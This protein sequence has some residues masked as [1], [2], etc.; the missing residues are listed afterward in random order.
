MEIA[1]QPTPFILT[2]IA[3]TTILVLALLQN[4]RGLECQDPLILWQTSCR[5]V[6]Q[7]VTPATRF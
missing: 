1:Y 6:D 4:A 3:A 5:P 7:A 2:S